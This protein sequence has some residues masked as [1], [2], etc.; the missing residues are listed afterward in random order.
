MTRPEPATVYAA[1]VLEDLLLR[2]P[3]AKL[4]TAWA[5]ELA[6]FAGWLRASGARLTYG[7][8]PGLATQQPATRGEE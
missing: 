7:K 2:G 8:Q 5:V 3:D 1:D 6:R 4:P